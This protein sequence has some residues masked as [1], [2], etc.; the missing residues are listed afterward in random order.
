MHTLVISLIPRPPQIC[1]HM[2]LLNNEY[3]ERQRLDTNYKKNPEADLFSWRP[4]P[5]SLCLPHDKIYGPSVSYIQVDIGKAW[6]QGYVC[7]TCS[8][9][10]ASDCVTDVLSCM[11]TCVC[12][13]PVAHT[14]QVTVLLTLFSL[15]R[16]LVV[17]HAEL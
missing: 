13:I 10:H 17:P 9:H 1:I 7:A 16:I 11:C 14:M 5:P 12:A 6:E 3:L 15:A 2:F 4:F 8:T